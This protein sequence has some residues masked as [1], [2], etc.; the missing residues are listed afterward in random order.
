MLFSISKQRGWLDGE[1]QYTLMSGFASS[2][3]QRASAEVAVAEVLEQSE[4]TE[5]IF[6]TTEWSAL[7]QS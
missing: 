3:W 4:V 6:T 2:R 7:E 5:G 1:S